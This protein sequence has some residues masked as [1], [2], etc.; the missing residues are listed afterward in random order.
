MRESLGAKIPV[1]SDFMTRKVITVSP[2][3]DLYQAI[4]LLLEH[5]VSAA[6][7]VSGTGERKRL[8]GLVSEKDCLAMLTS[9]AFYNASGGPVSRYMTREVKTLGPD[10]DIFTVA[11]IFLNEPYRR[12]PVV[13]GEYLVGIVSRRDV[14]DA[15]RLLWG[16]GAHDP[17]D[18][19]YLTEAL[20]ARL[21]ADGV[22]RVHRTD[23]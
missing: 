17:P 21:G 4:S 14:L 22:P 5:R 18:P 19:G 9:G 15:S 8:V 10:V 6:P 13:Q 3:M 20:K 11:G 7:V 2:D 23:G 16:A 12:L 1:A